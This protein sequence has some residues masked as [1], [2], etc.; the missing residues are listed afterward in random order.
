MGPGSFPNL[1]CKRE[2][3]MAISVEVSE[4]VENFQWLTEEQS[5][6]LDEQQRR[7]ALVDEI[8]KVRMCLA[9][10]ADNLQINIGGAIEKKIFKNEVK[11]LSEKV[12]CSSK[13]IQNTIEA[14]ISDRLLRHK[15]QIVNELLSMSYMHRGII[16]D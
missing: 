8:A 15:Q 3:S 2:V 7:A 6:K 13:N 1:S 14:Q 11:Y 4:L 9:F 12:K 5:Y 10:L 16:Y